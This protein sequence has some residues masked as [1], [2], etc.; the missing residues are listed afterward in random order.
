MAGTAG[1]GVCSGGVCVGTCKDQSDQ[2]A[3]YCSQNG[4]RTCAV[5]LSGCTDWTAT[6]TK[7]ETVRS[8]V[9]DEIND[10]R[11]GQ[12]PI[13][14]SATGKRCSVVYKRHLALRA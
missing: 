13:A 11:V 9:T 1:G 8:I 4:F 10:V 12:T 3:T 14:R 6:V 5:G 2:G 7:L